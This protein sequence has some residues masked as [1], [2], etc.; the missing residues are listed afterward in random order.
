MYNLILLWKHPYEHTI[1]EDCLYHTLYPATSLSAS[2]EYPKLLVHFL[3]K[4][5]DSF[6]GVHQVIRDYSGYERAE[7]VPFIH[8]LSEKGMLV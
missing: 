8:D 4:L 1:V 3:G 5:Y 7:M 6:T 2:M